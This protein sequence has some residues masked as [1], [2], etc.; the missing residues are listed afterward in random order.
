[1]ETVETTKIENVNIIIAWNRILIVDSID[2]KELESWRVTSWYDE[3]EGRKYTIL[4]KDYGKSSELMRMLLEEEQGWWMPILF[5][6]LIGLFILVSLTIWSIFVY[7]MF[8]D[9]EDQAPVLSTQR[10]E[11]QE[12]R[13]AM[14]IE[15]EQEQE[16]DQ[17]IISII[18]TTPVENCVAESNRNQLQSLSFEIESERN[19][20]R[21]SSLQDEINTCTTKI[22][23]KQREISLLEADKLELSQYI[24]NIPKNSDK[25]KFLLHLGTELSKKC[26]NTS[27][28]N[29]KESCKQLYYNYLQND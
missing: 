12:S 21:I 29:V 2:K 8:S 7:G 9:N 16:E 5:K 28:E 27:E 10:I 26:E 1:M 14:E 4:D 24:Q 22:A 6:V 15:E 17:P 3:V 23:E 13:N 25:E 18:D 11:I 20:F 19:Q